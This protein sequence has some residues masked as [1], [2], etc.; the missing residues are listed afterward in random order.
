MKRTIITFLF[1]ACAQYTASA[2]TA[3]EIIRKVEANQAGSSEVTATLEITD[4]FGKRVKKIHSFSSENGD[5]MLEF[6][7]PEEKGQKILRL[8]NEIYLYYPKAEEVI[9]L[10]GDSLKDSVMGSDFSYEDLTADKSILDRY[11]ATLERN[12]AV[13]GNDCYV[14]TL[15]ATRK[16]VAYPKQVVWVDSGLFAYRKGESYSKSGKLIKRM[17]IKEFVTVSGKT[18]ASNTEMYDTMKKNSKTVFIVDKV[19][20]GIKIDPK[21]FSYEEL[22]W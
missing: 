11:A 21:V 1:F 2:L 13:D 9:H 15:T 22:S 12:E 8:K 17:E 18:V 10:Q 3:E 6:T 14:I 5:M 19:R 16:D 20:L 4:T 7:N